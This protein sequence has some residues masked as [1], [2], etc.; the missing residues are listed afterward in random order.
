M[1]A[2]K[3]SLEDASSSRTVKKLKMESEGKSKPHSSGPSTIA[4]EEVDF[5]R[6]GGTPFTPLEVK[7]FRAEAIKEANAELFKVCF[8]SSRDVSSEIYTGSQC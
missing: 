1:A 6:G 7:T 2:R 4:T 3:R 8:Y 5:P